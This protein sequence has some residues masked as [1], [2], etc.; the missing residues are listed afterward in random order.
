MVEMSPRKPRLRALDLVATAAH[1][2][3]SPLVFIG[4][5]S[6]MLAAGHLGRLSSTQRDYIQRMNTAA[7]RLLQLVENLLMVN[8]SHYGRLSLELEPTTVATVLGEVLG[9]L[10]PRLI[11]KK[12]GV[13]WSRDV[14]L[15]P[16]LA[17]AQL[18]Y[19]ILFNLLDNSAKHAQAPASI[20]IRFRR[21]Q[22]KLII[23]LHDRGF[24]I[25]PSDLTKL[26]ERFGSF[27]QP[28][29]VQASTSGLGLFIVKSLVE[30]MGGSITAKRMRQGTRF[31]IGLS[32]VHQLELFD[33][34]VKKTKTASKPKT[35]KDKDNVEG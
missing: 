19:Q 23:Q 12:I 8:K 5:L 24:T 13:I 26:F 21:N 18:L 34:A 17:D 1:E 15:P 33:A 35:P 32:I 31:T 3:K 7:G 25:K 14:P 28:L 16:V 27:G 10:G 20:S 29:S 6:E 2:L 11:E 4:G 22:D 30:L 9:E